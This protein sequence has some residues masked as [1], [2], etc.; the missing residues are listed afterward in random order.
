MPVNSTVLAPD[1]TGGT[2]LVGGQ[3][4]SGAASAV[5]SPFV[6]GGV[7]G[8]PPG[9]PVIVANPVEVLGIL[10]GVSEAITP[11][12]FV[13]VDVRSLTQFRRIIIAIN[14]GGL[15]FQEIAFEG[16]PEVAQPHLGFAQ[17]YSALGTIDKITDGA[18]FRYQFRMLRSPAWPGSPELTVIAYNQAGVES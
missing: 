15:L 1:V 17:L 7:V 18:Y 16:D 3:H 10:P 11:L 5:V 12:T 4:R 8:G 2:V 14:F 9:G 6:L 13:Q